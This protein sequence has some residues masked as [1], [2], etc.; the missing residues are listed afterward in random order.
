[1]NANLPSPSSLVDFSFLDSP[2]IRKKYAVDEAETKICFY[3]G[4]IRCEKCVRKLEGLVGTIQGLRRLRVEM[5]KNLAHVEVDPSTLSFSDIADVIERLG[6]HPIPLGAGEYASENQTREDRSRLIRLAVAATCAGNIMTF[7]FATYLGGDAQLFSW[8]SFV[9]YLP[10]VTY[11]AWPFYQG[12]WAALRQKRISI[13]LPMAVASLAGFGLSV[14]ALL[15]GSFDVYFDSLSGFL[16]LILVARWLQQRMQKKYLDAGELREGLRLERVRLVQGSTWSWVPVESLVPQQEI[17]VFSNETIPADAKL[18]SSSAQVSLAWLTG[19]SKAKTY[20]KGAHLPAGAKVISKQIALV[21]ETP[22][23]Q[24]NF[25]SLMREVQKFSLSENRAI[26]ESDS[27]AQW[28]LGYVFLIAGVFVALYWQ[29]SPEEAVRRAFALIVLACPC[30]MAFGT[31][32]ALALS[33]KRANQLGLMVR[34]ANVFEAIKKARTVFL[35]KTGT[36]TETELS[37]V[38]APD[39]VPAAIQK[40]VLSLENLSVH[41]MAFAFRSAFSNQ[42]LVAVRDHQ[43]VAGIGV[44]GFIENQFYQLRASSL[45]CAGTSC[46]LLQGS[47]PIWTFNFTSSYRVGCLSVLTSLRARG[48]RLILLS[49]DSPAA[50]ALA[51]KDLGFSD[52]DA[53]SNLTPQEKASVIQSQT[54]TVMVGD[55]INDSLALQ[56]ADVGIAASGGV[57]AALKSAGVYL[58][59]TGVQGLELLFKLSDQAYSLIRQ[60]LLLSVVYNVVGGTLALLGYINPFVAAVLMPISSGFILLSTWLRSRA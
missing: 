39:K 11:V 34:D 54:H 43:E 26:A 12:A 48:L 24:T 53:H 57:E 23:A 8:L 17:S 15:R 14:G 13:D 6:F 58:G 33:L 44:S 56:K 3:I 52:V 32:L 16:F 5:G 7:A 60:N 38:E 49:G 41:P 51:A 30:A 42:T 22:L 19:E 25:G 28:L 27:W 10:V 2:S 37:L 59:E 4:G 18:L 47:E 36:L 50:V 55:G 1:M 40:I 9:L 45:E 46:V 35:D 31:P 29:V 20:L 21:V